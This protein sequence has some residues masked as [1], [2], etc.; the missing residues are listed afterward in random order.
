M[1]MTDYVLKLDK[2]RKK[3]NLF[4]AIIL[5]PVLIAIIVLIVICIIASHNGWESSK[6]LINNTGVGGFFAIAGSLYIVLV[7]R[8]RSYKKYRKL[9]KS[10]FVQRTLSSKYK[11]FSYDW[12][13]GFSRHQVASFNLCL[14]GSLFTSEDYLSG[15]YNDIAFKQADVL[16][17]E[18]SSTDD[19]NSSEPE[20]TVHFKGR[21][22]EFD[23]PGKNVTGIQIYSKNYTLPALKPDGYSTER[24]KLE[25]AHFNEVFTVKSIDEY[26]A[27]YLLTPHFLEL[28]EQFQYEYPR[29]TMYFSKNKLYVGIMNI[30]DTFEPP[31][32]L[33]KI[34]YALQRKR[35]LNDVEPIKTI[36]DTIIKPQIINSVE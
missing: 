26:E 32:N 9:Y 30:S 23:F 36:I 14:M 8:E 1:N 10:S 11:N 4:T 16:V 35:I 33:K 13:H 31:A 18:Y 21:M 12:E 5:L 19:P 22:Y 3:A 6:T 15:V 17:E 20:T 7:I 29:I 27:F 34:D 2:I 25:N 28:L 24:V